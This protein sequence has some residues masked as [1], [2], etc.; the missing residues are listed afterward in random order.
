MILELEYSLIQSRKLIIYF[1]CS[2]VIQ[3]SAAR[4]QLDN[5]ERHLRKFR[6]E[7]SHIH[8]WFVKADYEIRKIENKPVSKNTKEEIDWIRVC[9][10]EL[11]FQQ[12]LYFFLFLF[13]LDDKK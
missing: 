6:K 1:F 9:F 7:Y 2:F 8:E 11:N 3:V 12:L 4:N 10:K 13:L 5:V